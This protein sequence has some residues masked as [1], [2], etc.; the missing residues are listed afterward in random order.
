MTVWICV[1]TS[2]PVGDKDHLKVSESEAAANDWF[3]EDD[4]E[5]LVLSIG[6]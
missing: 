2:R 5:G 4:P 1:D 6:F 3:A